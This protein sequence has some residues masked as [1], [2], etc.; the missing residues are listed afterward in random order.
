MS[1]EGE[2]VRRSVP[3][4]ER[5]KADAL[6]NAMWS[7]SWPFLLVSPE[8]RRYLSGL[9]EGI[10]TEHHAAGGQAASYPR[11]TRT[12]LRARL[13]TPRRRCRP[14]GASPS[15]SPLPTTID[16]IYALHVLSISMAR[17]LLSVVINEDKVEDLSILANMEPRR[18][19][20]LT[21]AVQRRGDHFAGP[22]RRYRIAANNAFTTLSL[23]L[24]CSEDLLGCCRRLLHR[25]ATVTEL[26]RTLVSS[27]NSQRGL[28]CFRSAQGHLT[29][30][31][32]TEAQV[33]HSQTRVSRSF[34][35][36]DRARCVMTGQE[37]SQNASRFPRRPH[38]RGS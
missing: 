5:G 9:L 11:I 13:T 20:S 37:L 25:K 3:L 6:C 2:C 8:R 28:C 7:F 23:F 32:C 17:T 33:V 19:Q 38:R 24:L 31:T 34:V 22:F 18:F 14:L 4:C 29:Y 1:F 35:V 26:H 27:G 16:N 36:D 12:G 21:S 30:R 15:E 10:H